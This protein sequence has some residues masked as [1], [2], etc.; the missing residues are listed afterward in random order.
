[1]VTY[2][3]KYIGEGCLWWNDFQFFT[4]SFVWANCRQLLHEASCTSVS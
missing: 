3:I 2:Y 4:F 1:M